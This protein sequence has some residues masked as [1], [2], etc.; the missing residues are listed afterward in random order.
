[1]DFEP[2]HFR[3][4][5]ATAFARSGEF[6]LAGLVLEPFCFL[7]AMALDALELPLWLNGEC[8][9][10]SE[11]VIAALIC[12]NR[13]LDGFVSASRI[14]KEA[15]QS[16]IL[17]LEPDAADRWAEYLTTCYG[18]R[19]R[20]WKQEVSGPSA[21]SK[22]PLEEYVV[23]YIMRHAHGFTRE[24]LL[25][26]PAAEVFWIMESIR[27]QE[28]GRS[29]II[30]EAEHQAMELANTPEALAETARREKLA[31]EIFDACI[32][33]GKQPMIAVLLG[34]LIENKLPKNWRAKLKKKGAE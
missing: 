16:L 18:S 2:R 22:A 24:E 23:T 26:R 3:A 32:K 15:M 7:H 28:T 11:L 19:P 14:S 29:T 31:A 1:M 5:S 4:V 20:K 12:S 17:A 21:L 25:H 13:G 33:A 9:D 10:F 34:Q 8:E 27:E 6:R 30:T